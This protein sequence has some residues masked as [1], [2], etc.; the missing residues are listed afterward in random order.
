[1]TVGHCSIEP[2][3]TESQI[4]RNAVVNKLFYEQA[5]EKMVKPLTIRMKKHELELLNFFKPI[6]ISSAK[7]VE[8]L[9]KVKLIRI[10]NT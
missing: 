8:E 7:T 5:L 4:G 6:N 10:C 3:K 9:E 2:Y 1:M